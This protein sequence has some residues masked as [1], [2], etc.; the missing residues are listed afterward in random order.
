VFEVPNEGNSELPT[1]LVGDDP[2]GI[3]PGSGEGE[4]VMRPVLGGLIMRIVAKLL[5]QEIRSQFRTGV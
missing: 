5:E 4:I 2:S 1:L 3:E